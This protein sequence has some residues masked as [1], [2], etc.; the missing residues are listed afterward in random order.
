MGK[1]REAVREVVDR[2]KDTERFVADRAGALAQDGVYSQSQALLSVAQELAGLRRTLNGTDVEVP[3]RGPAGRKYQYP[4]FFQ[5]NEE[6]VKQG[7]KRDKKNTYEHSVP[8]PCYFR[9][10][11]VIDK[12]SE[13]KPTF[14]SEDV[15]S[16]S[17]ATPTYQVYI[18]LGY[19]T[20]QGVLRAQGRGTYYAPEPEMV[21]ESAR[22]AWEDLPTG[23]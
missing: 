12:L 13:E 2:L 5:R 22:R 19:L 14:K 4:R 20:K 6:L 17:E 3:E 9:V 10:V 16:G 15:I 7:L 18:T 1:D 8:K 11:E 23:A 21:L